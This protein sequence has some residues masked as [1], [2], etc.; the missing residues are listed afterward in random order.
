LKVDFN[1]QQLPEILEMIDVLLGTTYQMEGSTIT[2]KG[3]GCS[4]K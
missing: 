2:L 1:N 3:E 4:G